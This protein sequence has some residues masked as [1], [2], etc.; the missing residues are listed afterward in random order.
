MHAGYLTMTVDEPPSAPEFPLAP[1]L[2]VSPVFPVAPV[3]PVLPVLPWLPLAPC[4]PAGP[5]QAV[6]PRPRTN[7]ADAIKYFIKS[8][9]RGQYTDAHWVPGTLLRND[10][11]IESRR[12]T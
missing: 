4:G 5:V 2:P 9:Q 8:L 6:I 3:F 10:A 1:V 12:T 7:N 11:W